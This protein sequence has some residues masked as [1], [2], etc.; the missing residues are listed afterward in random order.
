MH[1][2]RTIGEKS[3]IEPHLPFI[4]WHRDLNAG[5]I[6]MLTTTSNK[7]NQKIHFRAY[8]GL[9][10]SLTLS[11]GDLMVGLGPLPRLMPRSDT[12]HILCALLKVQ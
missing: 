4:R 3:T 11:K 10:R 8:L 6:L 5:L 1:T 2:A 12:G 7:S 9:D